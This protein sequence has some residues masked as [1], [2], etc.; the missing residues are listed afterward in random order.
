MENFFDEYCLEHI[1]GKEIYCEKINRSA[2]PA[3]CHFVCRGDYKAYVRPDI[4]KLRAENRKPLTKEQMENQDLVSVIIPC[5]E[6]DKPYLQ[7]TIDETKKTAAG[8]LEYFVI[9]DGWQD[10]KYGDYCIINDTQ[11]GQRFSMNKAARLANG[12]YL[13]RLDAHCNLSEGWDARLKSS[14]KEQTL[15]TTIFDGLDKE[16]WGGTGRDNGF[17]RLTHN[18]NNFYMRGWKGFFERELEEETMGISGTAWMVPKEYYWHLG[19]CDEELGEYGAIGAEWPLKIWLTG[20][21]CIIRTDVV[22]YHLF[23]TFAPFGVIKGEKEKALEKLKKQW[24]EFGD[25]R[26][27]RPMG[28][29]VQKFQPLL[30]RRVYRN[31]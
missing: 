13:F 5:I 1:K 7:R 2:P 25:P 18:L 4:E 31:I 14:C 16:T 15:V 23:R 24:M 11:R 10:G 8:R 21:R 26:I 22:C 9:C 12:K 29:L 27:I 20:G 3:F 28:W 30:Q 6:A 19:G 17:V